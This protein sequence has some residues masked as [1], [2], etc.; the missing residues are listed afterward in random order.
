M[1]S[2][3]LKF[4]KISFC[5]SRFYTITIFI[6]ILSTYNRSIKPTKNFNE[7]S[8]A[9]NNFLPFRNKNEDQIKPTIKYKRNKRHLLQ[10]SK[11][12]IQG[13]SAE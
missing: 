2:Q 3:V 13:H 6:F 12:I 9:N 11:E 4:I 7:K 10:R 8:V 1:P 5:V